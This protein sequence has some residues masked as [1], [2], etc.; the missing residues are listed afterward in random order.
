MALKT[1][2]VRVL[3]SA[4]ESTLAFIRIWCK[5]GNMERDVR[6]ILLTAFTDGTGS[7]RGKLEVEL[8]DGTILPVTSPSE[9]GES[10]GVASYPLQKD[11]AVRMARYRNC[12]LTEVDEDVINNVL[13]ERRKSNRT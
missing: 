8:E 12:P 7:R 4:L 13:I 5:I 1:L 6:E 11:A 3:S 9:P 10:S 2:E